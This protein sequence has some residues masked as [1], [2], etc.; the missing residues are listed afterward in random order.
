ME[1]PLT[2]KDTTS[3]RC[4]SSM[5]SLFEGL[6]SGEFVQASVL[7]NSDYGYEAITRVHNHL[8]SCRSWVKVQ[9]W[10]E[11]VEYTINHPSGD[12]YAYDTKSTGTRLRTITPKDAAF[13][14]FGPDGRSCAVF[15][16]IVEEPVDHID[17]TTTRFS[18]VKVMNVKRFYYETAR[19]SFVYRLVVRWEGETKDAAKENGM[20]FGIYLET[21][22]ASK[23][24]EFP[25]QSCVSFM[26]KTLDLLSGDSRHVL[27]IRDHF[28]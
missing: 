16:T 3:H 5:S 26:E 15:R 17:F 1:D 7:K 6:G 8:H 10:D 25:E 20:Q 4:I 23:M 22:D 9:D 11:E 24:G 21:N 14:A 12:V 18:W 19:S 13:E 28:G 2:Y 27:E